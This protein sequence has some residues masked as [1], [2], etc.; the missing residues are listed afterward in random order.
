MKRS[1]LTIQQERGLGIRIRVSLGIGTVAM[2]GPAWAAAAGHHGWPYAIL[3][4]A[5]VGYAA[6]GAMRINRSNNAAFTQAE[7][8]ADAQRLA[9][10][11]EVQAWWDG[12]DGQPQPVTTITVVQVTDPTPDPLPRLELVQSFEE[13]PEMEPA[14]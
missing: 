9:V 7:A 14:L 6:A 1:I 4:V 5:C 8:E 3:P 11:A 10:Q 12:S 13:A 2:V